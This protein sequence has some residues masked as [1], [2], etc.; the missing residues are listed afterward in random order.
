MGA[1]GGEQPRTP[2]RWKLVIS[3]TPRLPGI[4]GLHEIM[5]PVM[6]LLASLDRQ[7]DRAFSVYV[8]ALDDPEPWLPD[9]D[10]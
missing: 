6:R 2:A 5:F 8:G 10:P 9:D 4:D 7:G 1:N 3:W